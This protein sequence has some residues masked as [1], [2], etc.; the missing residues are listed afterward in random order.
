MTEEVFLEADRIR[1]ALN[2]KGDELKILEDLSE[3]M[4]EAY[5][6]ISCENSEFYL[7]G[8]RKYRIGIDDPYVGKEYRKAIADLIAL[9]KERI[10]KEFMEL[11]KEFERI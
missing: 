1:L 8:M 10:D 2:R 7:R 4:K 5:T 9:K 11:K 6:D 3:N